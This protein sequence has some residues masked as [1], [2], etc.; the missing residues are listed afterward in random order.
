MLELK[1]IDHTT[2]I[3]RQLILNIIVPVVIAL[4]MLAI[5]NY[6]NTKETLLEADKTKSFI[7]SDEIIGILEFQDVALGI[8]EA[9]LDI[10]LE[11]FSSRLVNDY[12]SD[13][14]NIESSD[15]YA[16]RRELGMD[17]L[18]QDIYVIKKNG[19][20]VN[21][22][23]EKDRNL[24]SFQFGDD[25]KQFLLRVLDDKKFKAE[26]FTL[27]GTTHK[28]KKYCYHATNDGNYIIQLG[29]YNESANKLVTAI[30]NRINEISNPQGEDSR[31]NVVGVDLFLS[32]E[33]P[34]SL[35]SDAAID[36][37]EK[38]LLIGVFKQKGK[39]DRNEV[40]NE[41]HLKYEYAF[42]ERK[43]T[44]LYKSAV[45]RI[46]TDETDEKKKLRNELLKSLFIFGATLFI[47]I[48]LI[49]RKTQ[50]ITAPIKKLVDNVTR[51]TDGHLNE[52]AEVLGNNEITTLSEKFNNMIERLERSYNELEQ[53]VIERT[54]EIR[55]QKEEIENQRDDIEEKNQSIMD[56][57]HYAKRIQNAILPAEDYW[58]S[59]LSESFVLYKPKDIVS[60]DFYWMSKKPDRIMIAAVDCTGHGV[61]GAFMSIVGYNQLMNAVN[62]KGARKASD[63][64][65]FLNQ[66][67]TR[68]LHQK[69]GGSSVK[70]GMDISL[71]SIDLANMKLDYA[72][73]F[74]PMYLVRDGNIQMFKG[75]KF[76][77]GA[78]LDEELQNFTNQEVA[79]LP[80][81]S[82]YIYSAGAADHFGGEKGKKFKYKQFEDLLIE[83]QP[84]SMPEQKAILDKTIMSWMGKLEQIDDILVI[85]VKF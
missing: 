14:R 49:F 25:F 68:S 41:R 56:S 78:F 27:E 54:A 44:D 36:E 26:S 67:V 29:V 13:S 33:N 43:N 50:V 9:P 52:R 16:I 11:G 55:K 77:I 48:F 19:I 2:T 34:F 72:G 81:D 1:K 17:T 53:K 76:P 5:L 40:K 24:N 15:L 45:I 42:M 35:N 37:D 80:G 84:K 51:I 65:D 82:I 47:V 18:N 71:C 75:D 20:I 6:Q 46:I 31:L 69:K 60:G 57:I 61:P 66:G 70:D 7:I 79:L 85:G 38:D 21:T 73:A 8:I 28:L 62:V 59:G 32:P 23:F 22:T 30:K 74:N 58:R 63:I 64:L 3:F 83:I 12:F 4:L 10:Q 39:H